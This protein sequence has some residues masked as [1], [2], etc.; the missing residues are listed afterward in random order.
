MPICYSIKFLIGFSGKYFGRKYAVIFLNT[1]HTHTSLL[2]FD[3][4][5]NCAVHQNMGASDINVKVSI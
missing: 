5:F 2:P 1:H 3:N 4:Y